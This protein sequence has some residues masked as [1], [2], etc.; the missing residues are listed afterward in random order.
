MS[1]LPTAAP[2]AAIPAPSEIRAAIDAGAATTVPF[3]TPSATPAP[4]LDPAAPA[5]VAALAEKNPADLTP[6]EVK[7]LKKYQLKVDG[8]NEDMEIDLSNDAEVIKHLQM[9]KVAQKRMQ[10]AS[11]MQKA[12]EEFITL[13]KT[14]PERVLNDPNIGVDLKQLA[15][16]VINKQIE[17]AQKSPIELERDKAREELAAIKEKQTKDEKDRQTREMTRLQKENEEKVSSN[18]EAA[19]KTS[20]LPKT[21]Y[22]VRKMAEMMLLAL[23]N[24]VDL[25]PA[26]I[27]PIIRKQMQA[28]IKELFG[29]A[30]D[31]VLEEFVGKDRISSMRKKKVAQIKSQPVAQTT[32]SVKSA[33]GK[34]AEAPAKPKIT[35][36][37][38]LNS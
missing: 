7:T 8:K 24:N 19:L 34:P 32:G 14:D 29:A 35:L 13:L 15:Q 17:D 37:Q 23:Q 38:F 2:A 33:G 22:T 26:D 6:K 28:D 16:R 12:A 11:N 5:A 10:E 18:I 4:A 27:V 9:S 20:D 21:P 36:K 3:D 25:S 30:S 31:D 1:T